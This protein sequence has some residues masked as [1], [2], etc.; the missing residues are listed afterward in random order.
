MILKFF[1]YKKIYLS[2]KS[3]IKKNSINTFGQNYKLNFF[4]KKNSIYN[5]GQKYKLNF[6]NNFNKSKRIR[7]QI[8][9]KEMM[10]FWTLED[11]IFL[12]YKIDDKGN[13]EY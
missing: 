2:N 3:I 7:R 5:F 8:M 11:R 4:I 6:I 13:F 1:F 9:L 12:K 10:R